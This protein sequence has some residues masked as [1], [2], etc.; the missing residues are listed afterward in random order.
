MPFYLEL[1]KGYSPAQVGLLMMV[2]PALMG[3][4]SVYVGK[5]SD[6]FGPR[7]IIFMGLVILV[8][9]FWAVST[10]KAET[11]VLEYIWRM[12][13][14]GIGFGI[15]QTP[16]NIAIMGTAPREHLGV[17]SGLLALSRNLGQSTGLPFFGAV[18]SAFALAKGGLSGRTGI[19]T[20]SPDALVQGING[21]Y[22]L[23][24]LLTLIPVILAAWSWWIYR[25]QVKKANKTQ[26]S[27]HG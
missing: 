7:W 4:V 1:V 22:R 5:L 23:A 15:F 17:A 20:A 9:G 21:A 11:G 16:N 8:P 19:T 2:V 6:R 24:A 13:L 27:S 3:L 18:F 12:A 25:G 10:L 26:S 14:V